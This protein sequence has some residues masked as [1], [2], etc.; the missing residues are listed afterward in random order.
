[1]N[2]EC[3]RSTLDGFRCGGGSQIPLDRLTC[4]LCVYLSSVV[5]RGATTKKFALIAHL[6][7]CSSCV[8]VDKETIGVISY[9]ITRFVRISQIPVGLA[10][11][12]LNRNLD[13]Y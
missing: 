2:G 3:V 12:K 10:I 11:W 13:V 8:I 7:Q 1:M 4:V 5:C 9:E 6:P